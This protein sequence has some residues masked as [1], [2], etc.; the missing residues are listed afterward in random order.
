MEKW[1]IAVIKIEN[2]LLFY[3]AGGELATLQKPVKLWVQ[4]VV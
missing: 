3:V 1:I 2:W 4:V